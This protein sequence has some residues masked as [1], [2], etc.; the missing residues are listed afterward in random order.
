M[1]K[2][3]Q[4]LSF[5]SSQFLSKLLSSVLPRI[6]VAVEGHVRD[7]GVD[8]VPQPLAQEADPGRVVRQFLLGHG[9]GLA[10]AHAQEVRQRAGPGV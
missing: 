10:E 8:P 5:L 3:A 9:A 7:L 1:V 4:V 6:G 2:Q